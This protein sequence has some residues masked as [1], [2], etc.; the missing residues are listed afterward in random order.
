[1]RAIYFVTGLGAAAISAFLWTV[2]RPVGGFIGTFSGG[3]SVVFAI[4]CLMLMYYM[5]NPAA[6]KQDDD[7]LA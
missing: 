4:T 6:A 5:I 2:M 1:M 3:A 7:S